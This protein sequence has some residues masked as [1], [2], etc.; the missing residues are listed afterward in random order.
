MGTINAVC[1][2]GTQIHILFGYSCWTVLPRGRERRES[3]RGGE[4]L[5]EIAGCGWCKGVSRGEAQEK[6]GLS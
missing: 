6:I 5:R 3:E 1:K 4:R 2:H